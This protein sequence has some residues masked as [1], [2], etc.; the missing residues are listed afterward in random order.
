MP[1]SPGNHVP[2]ANGYGTFA[3]GPWIT[4]DYDQVNFE[5]GTTLKLCKHGSNSR[6]AG[7]RSS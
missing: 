4:G 7:A 5:A 3:P 2:L 6:N 1:T